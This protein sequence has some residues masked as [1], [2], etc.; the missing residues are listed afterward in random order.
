MFL[1]FTI[2]GRPNAYTE[3]VNALPTSAFGKITK[4]K[5]VWQFAEFASKLKSWSKFRRCFFTKLHRD[6]TGQYVMG[7]GKPDSVSIPTSGTVLSLTEDCGQPV[8]MSGLK[9]IPSYENHTKE[10]P[11]S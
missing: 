10:E 2:R 5:A 6:D 4:N 1:T 8:G 3:Y 7:F 11:T 9:L